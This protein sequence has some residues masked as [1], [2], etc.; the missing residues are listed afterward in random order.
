[1][2]PSSVSSTSVGACLGMVSKRITP[3]ICTVTPQ[4]FRLA[5]VSVCLSS[6]IEIVNITVI[7]NYI[8]V[9]LLI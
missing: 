1:M 8:R 3:I 6:I 5:Y 2:L 9:Y 7:H 4:Y